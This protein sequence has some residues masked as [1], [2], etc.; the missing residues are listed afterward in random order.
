MLK[1]QLYKYNLQQGCAVQVKYNVKSSKFVV[2]LSAGTQ[3]E[4]RERFD[5]L[6]YFA[7]EAWILRKV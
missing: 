4:K 5:F 2:K 1:S 7:L 6:I 3:E